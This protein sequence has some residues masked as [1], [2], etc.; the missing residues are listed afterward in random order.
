MKRSFEPRA[1]PSIQCNCLIQRDPL[2]EPLVLAAQ[3]IRQRIRGSVH[4][5]Q[6]HLEPGEI[7]RFLKVIVD[8]RERVRYLPVVFRRAGDRD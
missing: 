7:D 4:G 1:V 8:P 2:I 5:W 3:Q 6:G